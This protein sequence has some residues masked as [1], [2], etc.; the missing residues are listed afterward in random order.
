MKYLNLDDI[1]TI[2]INWLELIDVIKN[3]TAILKNN[4]FSQPL[5]TYVRNA[6]LANRIISM[7]AYLGG[8][9]CLFGVKWIASFPS[10]IE[11][12]QARANS[13]LILNDALTGQPLSIIN[14]ALLSGI[15][16]AAVSGFVTDLFIREV[17]TAKINCG[18]I[19][20]GPIGQLHAK[21][22]LDVYGDRI[23]NIYV[24]DLKDMA[25]DKMP[26]LELGSK[27][28]IVDCW[29][30]VFDRSDIFI[31]CTVSKARYVN[32][33]PQKGRLYLN[34][35]LRDFTPDFLK[36]TDVVIVDDWSEVCRE[37]TD[38]EKAHVQ[39]GLNQDEVISITELI[40]ESNSIN[41]HESSVM[42]N[43][44]GMSIYDIAIGSYFYN[45]SNKRKIGL[46][47]N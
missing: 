19:G 27:I 5:K 10:N 36:A 38:I 34:V 35:S 47:L 45:L 40:N 29:E 24:F 13:V 33:R 22:L 37:N 8:D 4:D 20:F 42:F 12:G 1:N 14:T 17:N 32:R 28:V 11:A 25:E 23:E 31:T 39:F 26:I 46:D 6:N 9:V 15:R 3:A 43:P 44:M 16:T 30:E 2:G 41:F 7:P 18:I 21:M